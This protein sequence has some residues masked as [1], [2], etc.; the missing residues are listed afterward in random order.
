MG[1][2][3]IFNSLEMSMQSLWVDV[4]QFLPQAVLAI[5]VLIV[6]WIVAG[7]VAGLVRKAF[8]TF[9]ID[10]ALDKAGV[11]EL[12]RKAGYKFRPG[13]FVGSLVKWFI[14]IAFAVVA[15]DILGLGEVT[16]FMREVVLGYLPQVF[17]AALILFVGV[18]VANLARNL[19][20]ATLRASGTTKPELYGKLAYVLVIAFTIMAILNQLR[21]ADELVEILFMG[22]VFALSLGAALAFGLGGRDAAGR[23]IDQITRK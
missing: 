14:I 2:N 9:H 16:L 5:L 21:I 23:Y 22:I 18:L 19:L 4:M 12:S 11:D 20:M 17:V 15:F 1:N 7:L 13:Y 6:G 8:K 3:N 10:D